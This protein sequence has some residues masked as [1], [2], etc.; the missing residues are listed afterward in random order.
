MRCNG[1][2]LSQCRPKRKHEANI[3]IPGGIVSSWCRP[4]LGQ[5]SA[6]SSLHDVCI[7]AVSWLG[8]SFD[9]FS[10]DLCGGKK[11]NVPANAWAFV[12]QNYLQWSVGLL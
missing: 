3:I 5:W 2:G 8:G 7:V 4:S 1:L 12:A 11:A 10:V 6:V 9:F